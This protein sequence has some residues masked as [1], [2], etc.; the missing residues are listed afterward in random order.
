MK[1]YNIIL[2]SKSPRRRE[3]LAGLG[4]EFEVKVVAGIDESY[5]ADMPAADVP[6]Y[7]ACKKADAY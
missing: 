6:Q 1:Q 5:P 3:L 7:I 2:S 4:L